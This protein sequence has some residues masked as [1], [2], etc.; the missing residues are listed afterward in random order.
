MAIRPYRRKR[1]MIQ[2]LDKKGRLLFVS[3][4][5][6]GYAFGTFYRK[7]LGGGKHRIKSYDLP[8]RPTREEADADFAKF[9]K[10]HG[11]VPVTVSH[12]EV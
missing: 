4:G 11:L 8:I 7:K 2:Y 5:I 6:G 12:L 9:I 3:S 10:K 1:K